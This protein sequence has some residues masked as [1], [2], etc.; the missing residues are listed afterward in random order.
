M[1]SLDEQIEYCKDIISK[2]KNIHKLKMYISLLKSLEKY[3]EQ[4]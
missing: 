4:I 2:S 3:K 1:K